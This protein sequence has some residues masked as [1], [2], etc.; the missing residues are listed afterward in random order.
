MLDLINSAVMAVADLLFGWLLRLPVGLALALVAVGTGSVITFA[1]PFTTN[2]DLLR[3]CDAD[4]RRLKELTREAKAREDKAAVRRYRL[5]QNMI[6]MTKMKQEGLPLLAA[7]LPIALLGTWCFHRLAFVPP[8]AGET[9]AVTAHFPVSAIGDLAHL[10][11]QAGLRE[12]GGAD[13]GGG[14]RWIREI[15]KDPDPKTGAALGGVATWRVQAEG[16]DA[17]YVLQIRYG[18]FTARK[19]LRV[20]QRI[21]AREIELCG[22]DR[23]VQGVQIGMRPVKFL[24]LVPGIRPLHMPPWLVAYFLIAIPSVSLLK[25]LAKV[26]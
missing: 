5:T 6:G 1:R 23:P 21:Y 7:I 16:R 20:G 10:V 15:V 26:Y 24:G 3:R 2:Q 18:S 12:A 13:A 19:E 22:A 14:A 8:K 11:P 9:V 17:P 25:R 4:K